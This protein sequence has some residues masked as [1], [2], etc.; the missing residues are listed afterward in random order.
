MLYVLPILMTWLIPGWQS[1]VT[2]VGGAL[3][4]AA[5]RLTPDLILLDISMSLLSRLDAARQINKSLPEAK[6]LF[7]T[8]HAS[9]GYATEA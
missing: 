4:E 5:E 2:A 9:P 7:L 8:M 3:I 6:L 1:T